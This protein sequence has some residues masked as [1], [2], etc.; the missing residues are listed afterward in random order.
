M[1]IL[2]K[3]LL[4]LRLSVFAFIISVQVTT[5]KAFPAT[6]QNL[7]DIFIKIDN[8]EI[9]LKRL[10]FLIE[11]QT[12]LSFAY[13]END[14]PLSRTIKVATGSQLLKLILD[15]VT[16]QT[17][18]QFLQK[19]RV[20]LVNKM[21][22][23]QLIKQYEPVLADSTIKGIVR[24]EEG[25]PLSNVTVAVKGT[26]NAV[27]TD[28]NGNFSIVAPDNAILVFSIVGYTTRELQV[29]SLSLDSVTMQVL[30]KDLNE[31]V[32]VGYQPQRRADL[33]GSVS[34]VNVGDVAKLPVGTLDQAL[35]GKAPGVR[36]TQSTGQP[37]EGVAVRIR[38]VGTINDNSPLFIIDGVP[39][40]DGINFL[41][42]NEIESIVV[43]KD[44]SS[45]A[46]YGARAANGVVIITTKSGKKGQPQFNYAAYEGIQTH[47]TLP[48]MLNTTQ[49]VELYNEAVAND[50]M[51]ISN[52]SLKRK[53]LPDTIAMANT[54]WLKAI[55]QNASISSHELS[56]SGGSDKVRY[57]VSGN[58]FRQEGIILNSW[59]ERY[60][61]L[62]KLN[63]DL[64]SKLTLAN[65]INISYAKRNAIGSSGDGY[66][67]NGGSVIRYALFRTPAIP[68]YNEDG[69]F[70]D[71]PAY[72]NFFGDGYNPVALAEKTDNKQTQYRVFANIYAEY[73]ILKNL[74]FKSDAGLD[75]IITN[76]KRFDEN[77][78]TNLRIN[79]P[80]RLTESAADNFNFIWNNTLRYNTNI[81]GI[82]TINAVVGTEAITNKSRIQGGSDSKFAEQISNLRYLGLGLSLAKN[83]F[84]SQQ[85]WALFSMFANVNYSYDNR[86]LLSFNAR[87]DGSSR[88]SEANKYGTFYSGSIGWNAHN[89]EWAKDHLSAF[90]KIKLRASF[91]Q[92]GNQ[93]IG[94][95]PWASIIGR[96][97]NY[98][99]G[100][101]P[102]S[103]PGYTIN[104]RGNENVKWESSTQANAGIDL[105]VWN[106]RLNLTVDYYVKRTSDML[107][108]IPLPLIGGSAATPYV[109]AGKVENK[110]L[111]VD[112]SYSNTDRQ[113]KY[114]FS[115]N[116]ATLRN[117]VLS[118]ASGEPIPGGRIDNGVYAT[119]T[120]V[121][122]PIGSFYLYQTDGIFQ[123]ESEIISSAYQGNYIRPGDVRFKDVNE[124]GTINEKDR[125]FL[126]SGI[127]KYSYGATANLGYGNFD[128]S[129]FFQGQYGNKLYLQVNQDIEG[130]YRAFN[131]T[132][133]VYDER[134]HGEGTS[135]TMPRVSWLGSTNNKTPSSRFLEDGS[136]IR[137]K[138]VQLGYNIPQQVI[139]RWKIK[140][141]RV[142]VTGQNL[143]T[144]TK[145]TGLD[146]EMHTSDNLNSEKYRGDVAAGIDWGTYPSAKSYIIGLNLNF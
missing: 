129:L 20:I 24:D 92:L 37:G 31:V 6:T 94:N 73:K 103:N 22:A 74:K 78:G 138:N 83:V 136:Y 33:A 144:L 104:S 79:S 142:Y 1:R 108:P 42:P 4:C 36:I 41:S 128:L 26:G 45:A 106:N 99:F 116:F 90:S 66:G 30:N 51:D 75:A 135:N 3:R 35:Q 146:P 98:V 112:L 39:T 57:Y 71:L 7:S 52:P 21:R 2:S 50:N 40:K 69:S 61:V 81:N 29:G 9:H 91:G 102:A 47:G 113:F 88:F 38:G 8:S 76:A 145:Y 114:E 28:A 16:D 60:S 59:Y 85:E 87:R 126:G 55:F 63:I 53:A 18:L 11:K 134:W 123:N 137:L 110:G 127:P 23:K 68:V 44:A 107:I 86:Y 10:F 27:Q 139:E 133:R 12:N 77:Y 58:Y 19:N 70:T 118:L 49:Y 15:Q 34:V 13:D 32:V 48:K 46:I 54:D 89:E 132:Q 65:N 117:K 62:S 121:G 125:T 96:G 119:L 100:A 5:V 64:T 105:G 25:A 67:G 93:D 17:G 143:W 97:F 140:G 141:I 72:P 111:E 124:D 101:P 80:S 14:V 131:L 115:V 43:L 130:F 82:H 120:T 95:Y 109:N 56:V 84:E 122:Q